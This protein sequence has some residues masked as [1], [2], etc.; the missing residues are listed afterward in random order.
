VWRANPECPEGI[1]PTRQ[2]S[3]TFSEGLNGVVFKR[4]VV[5][6]AC[7]GAPD[8]QPIS[9]FAGRP[10]V[11]EPGL[12]RRSIAV[13]FDQHGAMVM[14]PGDGARDDD[15]I[16]TMVPAAVIVERDGAVVTV[17][18]TLAV[19]VD[20]LDVAV[21]TV[22]GLDDYV[23]LGRRSDSRQSDGKRQSANDH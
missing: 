13:V 21:V 8:L 1:L 12:W 6:D 16:R 17:M 11:K 7:I 23:G 9:V 18:Q 4:R 19:L 15:G 20:D 22:V 10:G 2:D 3:A 5:G 14:V